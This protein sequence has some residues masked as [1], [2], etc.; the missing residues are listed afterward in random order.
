[1]S[2]PVSMALIPARDNPDQRASSFRSQ[3]RSA[4]DSE[5]VIELL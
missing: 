4:A 1:M 3:P 2:P 5:I